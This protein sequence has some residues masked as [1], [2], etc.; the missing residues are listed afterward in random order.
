[1]GSGASKQ[2]ESSDSFVSLD[3]SKTQS[4]SNKRQEIQDDNEKAMEEHQNYLVCYN[5]FHLR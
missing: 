2:V 5:F 3:D 4:S 1:M